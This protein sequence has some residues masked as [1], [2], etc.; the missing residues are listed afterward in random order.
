MRMDLKKLMARQNAA[1][2]LRLFQGEHCMAE[3]AMRESAEGMDW[4]AYDAAMKRDRH[5]QNLISQ[6]GMTV[7]ADDD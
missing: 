4:S 6:G 2:D 3:N 5:Y 7:E 1:S